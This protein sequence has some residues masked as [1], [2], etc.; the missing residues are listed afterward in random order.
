MVDVECVDKMNCA[1]STALHY[2]VILRRASDEA[3]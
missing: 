2:Y 1:L 3:R